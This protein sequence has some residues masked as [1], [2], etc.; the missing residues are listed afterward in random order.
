MELTED[1]PA[2]PPL[3][4]RWSRK[5]AHIGTNLTLYSRRDHAT[6]SG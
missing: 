1:H 4:A 6:L 2:S 3:P 5:L